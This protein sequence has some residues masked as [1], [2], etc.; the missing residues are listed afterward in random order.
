MN[1]LTQFIDL[2]VHLDKYLM[3]I[4]ENYGLLTYGIL[5]LV[6]FCETGLVVTPFLPGDSL[7]FA[8]GA[9]A[10]LGSLNIFTLFIVLFFA[11]V[12]GD[13]INYHLGKYI[14]IRLL[15]KKNLMLIK[16]DH[17]IKTQNFY[18]KYGGIAIILARFMPI[19]RTFAPFVAGIGNMK[20][21]KFFTFSL[22]SSLLWVS[23]CTFGGFFFGNLPFV[24]DNF[25]LVVVAI[26]GI[27]LLP[28]IIGYL[29][30]KV[31]TNATEV[32]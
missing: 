3:V 6:I 2:F 7:L 8:S 22:L 4:T 28:I 15:N 13:N 9:L 27:S 17:L 25:S 12:L 30:R 14:G 20:Y 24:K 31:S 23:L 1:L 21:I 32:N 16:E 11:V 29:R 18:D 5:F 10:A 26:I 19:I